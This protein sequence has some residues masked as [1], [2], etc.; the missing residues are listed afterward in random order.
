M[1][2]SRRRRHFPALLV[3]CIIS[4][5]AGGMGLGSYLLL[6]MRVS[7][8]ADQTRIFEEM[9]SKALTSDHSEAVQCLE[10]VVRYYPTGT[11]QIPGSPLDQTV[12]RARVRATAD[13][14]D[15]LR[16][17]TGSDLG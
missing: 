13:I 1:N 12:E 7:F 5:I 6:Q 4:I 16:T 17:S 8:A 14:I 9:R 11:K 2:E 15:H 3:I 10:Y